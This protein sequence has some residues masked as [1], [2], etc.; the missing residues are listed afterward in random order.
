MAERPGIHRTS[1]RLPD[2]VK[3]IVKREAAAEGCSMNAWMLRALEKRVL[4]DLAA[5]A[6]TEQMRR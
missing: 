1:L 5:L 3:A 4:E 2:H 6:R